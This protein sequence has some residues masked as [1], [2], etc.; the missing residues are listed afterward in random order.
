MVTI[1]E[2]EIYKNS[3]VGVSDLL[4]CTHNVLKCTMLAGM[5]VSDVFGHYKSSQQ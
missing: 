2:E 4:G 5:L 3:N 1:C